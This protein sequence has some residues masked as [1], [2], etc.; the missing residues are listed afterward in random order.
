MTTQIPSPSWDEE[1]DLRRWIGT[2]IRGKWVILALTVF[3]IAASSIVNY[4]LLTPVY[5]TSG[6]T[7]L[8]TSSGVKGFG[9]TPLG[10]QGFAISNSV[11]DP[12]Q[13]QLGLELEETQLLSKYEFELDGS[14]SLLSATA[15]ADTGEKAY[16]LMDSWLKTYNKEVSVNIQKKFKSSISSRSIEVETLRARLTEANDSL[17]TF[18]LDNR[19]ENLDARHS[20]LE[21]NLISKKEQLATLDTDNHSPAE[22][23]TDTILV[24]RNLVSEEARLK[25]S[26]ARIVNR[27]TELEKHLNISETRLRQLVWSQLSKKEA[28]ILAL[29]SVLT[30]EPMSLGET[31]DGSTIPNPVYLHFNQALGG[32]RVDL[33]SD[34][35]E[36]ELVT[37]QVA[38]YKTQ[39][40]ELGEQFGAIQA[41]L[42]Q[43]LQARIPL[44]QEE[45]K[46]IRASISAA[47][48]ERLRLEAA[49]PQINE[50]LQRATTELQLLTAIEPNLV[51]FSTPTTVSGPRMPSSPMAPQRV[52][53]ILLFTI[54]GAFL[55]FLIV[56]VAE[57]NR[58]RPVTSIPLTE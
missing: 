49:V 47:S 25:R 16:L 53:N 55:G 34:T 37:L 5:A 31:S 38:D 36:K 35:I 44:L 26:S 52:R 17:V 22:L 2:L 1:I 56:I 58:E 14:D 24:D 12:L 7:A 50:E 11:M 30:S 3:A 15:S 27:L 28:S 57:L 4:L 6:T 41:E 39:V 8:P 10:Y 45:I 29:E 46:Q 13:K 18:N 9:M 20:V 54:L 32:A 40:L 19:I 42:G 43:I 21:Q 48:I 51:S 23:S 33:A